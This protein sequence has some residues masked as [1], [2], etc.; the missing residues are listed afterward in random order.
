MN[1]QVATARCS[2]ALRWAVCSKKSRSFSASSVGCGAVP[3]TTTRTAEGPAAADDWLTSFLDACSV[4][5]FAA[6]DSDSPPP[7]NRLA[8][9]HRVSRCTVVPDEPTKRR[10]R[11]T[12]TMG[13]C[14]GG[15]QA[16]G[17]LTFSNHVQ[18]QR[19]QI[20]HSIDEAW[21]LL[22]LCGTESLNKLIG[23]VIAV[24]PEWMITLT[25]VGQTE[26][27]E[28]SAQ[29]SWRQRMSSQR[30]RDPF[31]HLTHLMDPRL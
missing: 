27:V 2:A 1:T 5:A 9:F 28:Q 17:K 25:G 19:G 18:Q 14:R 3:S 29:L 20:G 12:N 8:I 31:G 11:R 7:N 30:N 6:A 24:S 16:Q 26:S 23:K 22:T 13:G 10:R 4:D 15:K 21:E